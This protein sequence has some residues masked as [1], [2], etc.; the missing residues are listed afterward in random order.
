VPRFTPDLTNIMTSELRDTLEEFSQHIK[1]YIG[2][3][4]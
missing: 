4:Q 1:W 3:Q 2:Q